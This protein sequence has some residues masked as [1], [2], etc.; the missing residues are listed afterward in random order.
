[1]DIWLSLLI[2]FIA[3]AITVAILLRR[4]RSRRALE[5]RVSELTTLAEVGRAIQG[6]QLDLNR[7]AELVY[8]QA[9]QIVDTSIFQLGLLDGDRYRLLIWVM[10]GQRRPTAE[11]KL[12]PD[13]PGIVGWMQTSKQHL[14]I[15]DFETQ[16]NSL[17]A[18]PRYISADPPRS[19]VFVPLMV[20]DTVLGAMA[21]QSRRPD[22]FSD[23]HVRLLSIIAN[24]AAAALE[25]G[26]LYEQAHRRAAQ[27]ELLSEVSQHINAIQ[28]LPA[29]YRQVVNLVAEKFGESEVSVYEHGPRGLSL[30]AT[31]NGEAKEP[32]KDDG[33][34]VQAVTLRVP[35]VVQNLPEYPDLGGQPAAMTL[36]EI[37]VPIE[38]DD[39]V[40]GVLD[41]RGRAAFDGSTVAVFKSLAGQMAIAI[42]EAQVYAAEQR[43]AEHLAAIAQLSRTVAS[44]LELDDLFDEVLDLVDEHFGYKRVHIFLSQDND[45]VFR[46]GIGRGA[47]RWAMERVSRPLDGPGLVALAGRTRQPVIIHDTALHAGFGPDPGLEDTHSQMA[48][49]MMM[50][51]QLLGVL[52]I[53]S[54]EAGAFDGEDEQTLQ[55]LADTL[56]IAIR[57][58]RLFD[59]ER[60]RRRLAEILR[61]VSAA[62]AATLEL[63]IVFDLILN[64][65]ARVV[66]Y[67]VASI[68]LV[69]EI[70]ELVLRA[71]RGSP[72]TIRALGETLDVKML[73]GESL[74]AMVEF[75]EVDHQHQYH[76]LVNLPDP[77]VCLGAVLAL[78]GEHMGYLAVDRTG[79]GQYSIEEGELISA[80][81]SQAAV[82]IENA[83]L[84]SLQREQ[85][86]VSRTLLQVAEATAHASELGE[87]LETVTQL[88]PTL[89]GVE[90]CAVFLT[91]G[92]TFV[93]A[94]YGGAQ[95]DLFD[96][97]EP[98]HFTPE[99]W[100]QLA[101]MIAKREPGVIAPA[102]PDEEEEEDILPPSLR[103]MF[104]GVAIL[105]PLMA[106]THF[107]GVMI[108]GQTPGHAPFTA[109]RV[110]LLGGIADQMSTAI[111]SALL[112]QS[113]QEE[114]WV[115]AAL[116]QVAEAVVS[117]PTL[118]AGLETVARLI[119]MLV[120][121]EKV[122][123]FQTDDGRS[124]AQVFHARQV[125]GLGREAASRARQL[126]VPVHE[127]NIEAASETASPLFELTLPESI[128]RAFE[129]QVAMIWPLK[130]RGDLLG[131]LMVEHV[132][133]LGRR[134]SILDGIAQQLAMAM[135]NGR[136]TRELAMQQR[137]ERELELGRDIQAS[138][139]PD[140][141]PAFPNWEVCSYW[142]VARQVGGDFYDFIPLP[143]DKGRTRLGIVIAD[144]ADKGVPAA[145]FMALS[146]TLLRTVAINRVEPG[147]TLARTNQLIMADARSNQFVTVFYGVWEP[148]S[149]RFC[150]ATGGHNLPVWVSA[151]GEVHILPGRGA[152]LG[153]F[154]EAR[155]QEQET[156]FQPGDVMLLYTDGLTDAINVE[157]EE[158]GLNRVREIVAG[159]R[160]QSAADI[161]DT[162]AA[163]VKSHAGA[164][165][166]FD[167]LTMVA[168]K[169]V[170]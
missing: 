155:Y 109:Q 43:R 15:R 119:P 160:H 122:A 71:S 97:D 170:S 66:S 72:E 117:Q 163:S 14:L 8:E 135:E 13:S 107:Q 26:R 123:I 105:L 120:G 61:E 166:A 127:L 168:I 70:G 103:E 83:R 162:L 19:G 137:L 146:R 101:D 55:T 60:R 91:E 89:T 81:A 67:N 47:S 153:V 53:Q 31:S 84:Y 147:I 48:A 114:G 37:A 133:M 167:D 16:R 35:V 149:G 87:V 12:T 96:P 125:M 25:N 64:G 36:S 106:K 154:D 78:R 68:L 56:A 57:N 142:H 145:L 95:A 116:L 136:L 62:L 3:L 115:S 104:E 124:A 80:F 131:A 118:E 11:F 52:D 6:A 63:D 129:M 54:E 151:N 121:I 28:P 100:P 45:L 79:G 138:F 23:R 5:A 139:L 112:F 21:I 94:A 29:L 157:S 140:A 134:L 110:R 46:A 92:E 152:A 9:G 20:R 93:L 41:V 49:P 159:A 85:T 98:Y 27:L 2:L 128:A 113:Q 22:A 148:D 40:L 126:P 156:L 30:R 150:Y 82:A 141:C 108:V 18:K 32:L 39:R 86:W 143:P 38:I 76:A 44:T 111:E 59:S 33:P 24:H 77:H 34:V 51:G 130:T 10:D 17:P 99:E 90:Q 158:F 74:P 69:N 132:P 75:Q 102:D 144:V 169:R 88:T 73:S 58:A 7:L 161:L 164:M 1:M 165:E 4:L 65:L 42:L 50:A